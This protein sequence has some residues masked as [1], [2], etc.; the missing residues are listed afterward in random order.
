MGNCFLGKKRGKLKTEQDPLRF[1]FFELRICI[2]SQILYGVTSMRL[3]VS[4]VCVRIIINFS[5]KFPILHRRQVNCQLFM[6]DPVMI[7]CSENRNR[8]SSRFDYLETGQSKSV[9][10]PVSRNWCLTAGSDIHY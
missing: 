10:E 8:K 6:R 4:S 9:I 3:R 5:K 7:Q 2:P 1:P